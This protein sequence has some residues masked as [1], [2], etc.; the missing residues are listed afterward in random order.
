MSLLVTELEPGDGDLP[1]DLSSTVV[2]SLD[3]G[4]LLGSFNRA[5]VLAPSDIHVAVRLVRLAGET[6]GS[7]A[8]GAAFAVRAP[9]VGHVYVDL[10]TVRATA[11]AGEEDEAVVETL[12]WPDPERWIEKM[13]ASRIVS[14]SPGS[15]EGRPLVLEGPALYLDRLWRDEIAVADDIAART[16]SEPGDTEPV[17]AAEALARL[18]P[19][20]RSAEQRRAAATAVLRRLAVIAGGPGTGKTTTVARMLAALFEQAAAAGTRPPLV[21]LA[22]PTGKAAAR[23]AEAVR[24]EASGLE[25]DASLRRDLEALDASTV[26]RLLGFRPGSTTRFRHDAGDPLPYDVVVVDETS[27]LPLWLMARLVEAVRRD[28]RLVLI[29]DPEQLASVEAGVVLADVVGP[30]GH[31]TTASSR[32]AAERAELSGVAEPETSTSTAPTAIGD[33][34]VTLRTNHRFSGALAELAEA[35]RSGDAE[36]AL[37]ALRNPDPG[38]EW[39]AADGSTDT[40]AQGVILER[41]TSHG[42]MLVEAARSGGVESSLLAVDGFRLLCAHRRGAAGATTWNDHVERLVAGDPTLEVSSAWYVGR[43]VIVTSNDYALR[44]FNGDVGVVL[45]R[46]G[47]GVE[48][49]FRRGGDLLSVSPSLL[50]N[51]ATVY[52]MTIHKAQGSEFDEVAIV[53]P[54]PSSRVLTRE[55][56]YTAVTR[57]RHRVLLVGTED[58]LRAGVERRIA[59][60]SGLLH[61]LWGPDAGGS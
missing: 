45:P 41:A 1:D 4:S 18:F 60:A 12:A 59:R 8:L 44:L 10:S 37:E 30:A 61:R 52:A 11:S 17:R 3:P 13:A 55:L 22:A 5:G 16:S 53:L 27:M 19:G 6:D 28:A 38:I 58:A 14:T 23:L 25:I 33:C 9:R 54:D 47:G 20:D 42:R 56:L 57:A 49:V 48:A 24:A 2:R 21:A 7:V 50:G 29:G 35:V 51:V 40:D 46:E 34:V 26:H 15:E 32:V 43:P 36:R 31:L 39:I